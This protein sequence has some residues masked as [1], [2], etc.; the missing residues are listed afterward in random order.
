LL[1]SLLYA[2]VLRAWSRSYPESYQ[3]NTWLTVVVGV[4]YVLLALAVVTNLVVWLRVVVAFGVAGVPIVA[5][6]VVSAA[7]RRRKAHARW[8]KEGE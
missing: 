8:E 6:C 5:S 1:V 3:D 2:V 4:G 7:Q